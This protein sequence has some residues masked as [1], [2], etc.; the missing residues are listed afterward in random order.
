MTYRH[1]TTEEFKCRD[2]GRN[3]IKSEIIELL[4]RARAL[5]D[6]PFN[7]SSGYRCPEYNA[8]VGGVED[9]AH[10]KGLA[11]DIKC[12]RSRA[13]FKM[14]AALLECGFTRIGIS[15]DFIHVDIDPDKPREVIWPY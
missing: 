6:V 8:A 12:L 14:I 5:A 10:T 1:F 2:C 13:R 3:E 9:S 7:I 15:D 11:A 4:D